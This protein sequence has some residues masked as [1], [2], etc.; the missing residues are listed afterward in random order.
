MRAH[1]RLTLLLA[2]ATLFPAA[3]AAQELSRSGWTIVPSLGFG[4]VRVNHSWNSGGAEAAFDVE[5]GGTDWRADAFTS[6][7]GLGVGCSESCFEG[8]PAFALG[9]ARSVGALWVGGGAGTMKQHGSW[10]FFPYG[11]VSFDAEPVRLDLR[12]EWPQQD[13]SGVYFPILVG[14]PIG[15]VAR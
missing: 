1:R 11:R 7:R 15:F 9:A 5:Y 6:L 12:V 8:G 3:G 10:R 4:T 13:G 14:F 2:S